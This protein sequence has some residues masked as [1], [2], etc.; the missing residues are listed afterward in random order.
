MCKKLILFVP[1]V[2]LLLSSSCHKKEPCNQPD[3]YFP[4]TEAAYTKVPYNGHDTLK[5]KYYKNDTLIDTLTYIGQGRVYDSAF[6]MQVGETWE[7]HHSQWGEKYT[8]DFKCLNNEKFNIQFAV[9]GDEGGENF[10][11]YFLN[12]T[13][14]DL[15]LCVD[16]EQYGGYYNHKIINGKLY[17]DVSEYPKRG[18]SGSFN[19]YYA[20]DSG[21]LRI[22]QFN[23]VI[24]E[25]I[26]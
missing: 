2:L 12:E 15:L 7:C 13:L 8:I 23:S 1:I 9:L 25:L 11:V 4:L 20:K 18:K 14:E 5:F 21:I 3:E 22:E 16:W 10:R 24:L 17:K 26:D 6:I 19:L